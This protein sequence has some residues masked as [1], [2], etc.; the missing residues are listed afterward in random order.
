MIKVILNIGVLK[1]LL[2]KHHMTLRM[3]KRAIKLHP[4]TIE[5]ACSG[6]PIRVES[7]K[8]IARALSVD[9]DFIFMKFA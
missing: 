4:Q 9:F 2:D 1:E 5:M 3:L 6:F 8:K 7:A